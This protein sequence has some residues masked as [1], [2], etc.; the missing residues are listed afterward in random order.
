MVLW[1]RKCLQA[2][3]DH[4]GERIKRMLAPKLLEALLHVALPAAVVGAAEMATAV[5]R[6]G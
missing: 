1:Y 4:G 2:S 5:V 3:G 6:L